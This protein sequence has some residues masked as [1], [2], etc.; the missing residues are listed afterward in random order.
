MDL[1]F[2][3]VFLPFYFGIGRGQFRQLRDFSFR[4]GG[5]A[6][7]TAGRAVP[8]AGMNWRGMI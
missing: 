6:R 7:L 8:N 4:R 5:E 2:W 1:I 3:F